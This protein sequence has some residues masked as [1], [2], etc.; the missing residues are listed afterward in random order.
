[1]TQTGS[2]QTA[3]FPV[4]VA[5]TDRYIYSI[6]GGILSMTNR[7]IS[8]LFLLI[9]TLS[10]MVLFL[11]ALIIWMATV[12][13]DKRLHILHY[14][15]SFW[16]SIYTWAMPAW[17]VSIEG[18]EH[19]GKKTYVI[20]SNHQSLLDILVAFRIFFPFKW[21][22]KV[23]I[24]RI[25]FVGWNM[26]LNRYIKLVRGN[27]RSVRRMLEDC[28]T[29]LAGGSSVFLFP[30][31]TR[32][33]TRTVKP[34]KPGAFILAHTN[35]LPILPIAINGTRDALPRDSL[36]FH[37]THRI[38]VRILEEIPYASF[39]G[40]HPEETATMVRERIS[41]AVEGLKSGS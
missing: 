6:F 15:T 39:Q 34:F 28:T 24:F 22:S 23:E 4:S 37:G 35:K 5:I 30:E 36:N 31:G 8:I 32:S 21:V 19:I 1:M 27:K 33:K 18:R 13:F 10:S 26:T 16:A 17:K 29:A 14:F 9:I 3:L 2:P 20:V 38:T 25:P 40:L 7:I 41:G 11:I 12:F